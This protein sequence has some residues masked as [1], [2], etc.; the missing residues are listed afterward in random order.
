M[1]PVLVPDNEAR[2]DQTLSMPDEGTSMGNQIPTDVIDEAGH[3]ELLFRCLTCKRVAHWK[4]LPRPSHLAP[5]DTLAE[6]AEFYTKNWLCAD[7]SS[8]H[9]GLDKIIAWRPYPSN[10]VEH[11]G[12][13]DGPPNYKHSLPREYLVK[14]LDR[15][16]LRVQW[17]PHMWLLSTHPGKLKHFLTC[18][19]KVELLKDQDQEILSNGK[20]SSSFEIGDTSR[21]SS[22]KA[23]SNTPPSIHD[24]VPDAE[25]RIP[26]AWKT[27]DRILDLYLWH[28][29]RHPKNVKQKEK[30]AVI[31]SEGDNSDRAEEDLFDNERGLAFD[32]GEQP[33]NESMANISQWEAK[34]KRSFTVQDIEQVAW[35]FI[36]W[37]DLGY[38]DS[39]SLVP[40]T[41]SH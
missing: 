30:R 37:G 33:S 9:Y 22:V 36:K 18:G 28:P 8:Y 6:T 21:A 7:C 17:V 26:P 38:D 20:V 32:H 29:G 11:A 4:H 16:F 41:P 27:I 5:D 10:A 40:S 31:D 25:R 13:G 19:S 23:G 12:S 35:A 3:R 15:S 24:A 2:K 14:W 34:T 39:K 1:E